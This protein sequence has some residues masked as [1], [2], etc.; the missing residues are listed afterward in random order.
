MMRNFF[1]AQR[2][3]KLST[4]ENWKCSFNEN[5]IWNKNSARKEISFVTHKIGKLYRTQNIIY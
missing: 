5:I 1:A 3:C 2:L 4:E